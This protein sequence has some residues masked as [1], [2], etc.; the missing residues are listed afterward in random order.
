MSAHVG[1]SLHCNQDPHTIKRAY[2]IID[3]ILDK[4]L[5]REQERMLATLAEVEAELQRKHQPPSSIDGVS[6]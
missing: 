6:Y 5:E 1:L 4:E 3:H 2:R